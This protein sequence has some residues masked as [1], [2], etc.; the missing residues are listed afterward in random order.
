MT[1]VGFPTIA[2]R[3]LLI[4]DAGPSSSFFSTINP[5][6]VDQGKLDSSLDSLCR[7]GLGG[8]LRIPVLRPCAINIKAAPLDVLDRV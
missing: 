4:V 1:P 3:P 2:I 6:D 7:A 5:Q 8:L